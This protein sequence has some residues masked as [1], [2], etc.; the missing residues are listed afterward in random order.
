MKILHSRAFWSVLTFIG[1]LIVSNY[2][3]YMGHSRCSIIVLLTYLI[4]YFTGLMAGVTQGKSAEKSRA[5]ALC[6]QSF[7]AGMSGSVRR[8]MNGIAEDR[9]KLLTED[10]FFGPESRDVSSVHAPGN[11]QERPPSSS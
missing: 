7:S 10:E 1:V 2:M 8:V 9:T 6:Q 3:N 5:L 11:P 4:A